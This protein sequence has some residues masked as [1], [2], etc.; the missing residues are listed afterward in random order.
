MEAAI[1]TIIIATVIAVIAIVIAL[2][3]MSTASLP[4]P[5]LPFR[6]L[7]TKDRPRVVLHGDQR[8]YRADARIGNMTPAPVVNYAVRMF[9]RLLFARVSVLSPSRQTRESKHAKR[10]HRH[11]HCGNN[12][13]QDL[14]PIDSVQR[15]GQRPSYYRQCYQAP[16]QTLSLYSGPGSLN[17]NMYTRVQKAAAASPSNN[18]PRSGIA[19]RQ[20]SAAS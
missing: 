10:T 3:E 8:L 2:A 4:V 1:H 12:F 5:I 13:S 18:I 6:G 14:S 15:P 19:K 16:R 7:P 20:V 11:T 17:I 9:L